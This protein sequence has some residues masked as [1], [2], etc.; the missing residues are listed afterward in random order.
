M[1]RLI[2]DRIRDATVGM[3]LTTLGNLIV[4][5]ALLEPRSP[6]KT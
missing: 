5:P 4:L 3:T 6:A 2:L 1:G